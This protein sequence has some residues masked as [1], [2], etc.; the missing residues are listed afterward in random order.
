MAQQLHYFSALA[1]LLA[2]VGFVLVMG[3]VS[4]LLAPHRPNPEKQSTYECGEEPLGSA[5]VQFNMR[6]YVMGL[7]FLVFD[8]EVLLL[9]P[10]AAVYTDAA[11]LQAVPN[12]GLIA[13]A[14][15]LVFVGVLLL[16]LAY[17]W[18]RGDLDW[19]RPAPQQPE[20]HSPVPPEA[21]QQVNQRVSSRVV[22]AVEPVSE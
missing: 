9:F 6:F 20:V 7:V 11:Y 12:W 14:E 4:R 3:R 22:Q 15:V 13:L 5:W 17:V 18:Q 21:Y 1:Y 10:W 2:G 19:V 8:V 16:G